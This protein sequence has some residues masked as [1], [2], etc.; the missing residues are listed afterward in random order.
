MNNVIPLKRSEHVISDAELD[1]LAIDI[2]RFAQRHAGT[3]SL[4][5]GIR[6]LLS[7]AL[8]RDKPK[9]FADEI[10][11]RNMASWRADLK[12]ESEDGEGNVPA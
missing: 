9:T 6:K 4:S 11:E 10:L 1:K 12:K 8:K 5:H 7:D 2:S 3:L